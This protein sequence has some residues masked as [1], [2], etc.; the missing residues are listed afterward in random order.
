MVYT[1]EC[2]ITIDSMWMMIE[3]LCTLTLLQKVFL[4]KGIMVRLSTLL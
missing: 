2:F 3:V 4:R 1:C